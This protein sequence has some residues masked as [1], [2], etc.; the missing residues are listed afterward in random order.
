MATTGILRA[1]ENRLL[2]EKHVCELSQNIETFISHELNMLIANVKNI[3]SIKTSI[4]VGRLV[5]RHVWKL[6]MKQGLLNGIGDVLCPVQWQACHPNTISH[7]DIDN[8][9]I[10]DA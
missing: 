1:C 8:Q 5:L 6:S 4:T 7:D 9:K 2:K 3:H 10:S